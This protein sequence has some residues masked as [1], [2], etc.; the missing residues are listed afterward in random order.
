VYDVCSEHT[1]LTVLAPAETRF[2]TCLIM[3]KRLFQLRAALQKMVQEDYEYKRW[4]AGHP[5]D[6]QAVAK[7]IAA[8]IN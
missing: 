2:A 1:N 8:T 3:L 5:K 7:T 4:V 6:K